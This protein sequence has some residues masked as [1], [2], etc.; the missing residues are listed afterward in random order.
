M[1]VSPADKYAACKTA[2][3]L[4]DGIRA[5]LIQCACP[6]G[7]DGQRQHSPRCYWVEA[8]NRIY[9]LERSV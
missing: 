6:T 5:G 9:T 4:R 2:R 7:R 3:L 1:I 8:V